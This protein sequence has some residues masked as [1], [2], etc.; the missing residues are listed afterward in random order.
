MNLGWHLYQSILVLMT[1]KC[2]Q[3]IIFL[4]HEVNHESPAEFACYIASH[5]LTIP[6]LR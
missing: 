6:E 1:T 4:Q 5:T 3:I 2:T